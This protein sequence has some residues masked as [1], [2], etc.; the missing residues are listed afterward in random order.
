MLLGITVSIDRRK[1]VL[2]ELLP[3]VIDMPAFAQGDVIIGQVGVCKETGDPT[4][5]TSKVTVSGSSGIALTD[6]DSIIY[7]A[8]TISAVTPPNIINFGLTVSS[9]ELDTAMAATTDDYIPAFFEVRA[10]A[11]GEDVLI[12]REAVVINK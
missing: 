5:P 12:L 6:G 10:T 2:S 11:G 9:S 3:D 4:A 8:A 7:A 1:R